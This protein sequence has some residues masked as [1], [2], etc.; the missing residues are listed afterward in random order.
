MAAAYNNIAGVYFQKQELDKVLEFALK[1]LDIRKRL[2]NKRNIAFNMIN[3]GSVFNSMGKT[4]SAISYI[5]QGIELAQEVGTLP[6][7]R[8]GYKTLSRIYESSNDFREANKY[9]KLFIEINDSI[10]R[11]KS[12]R[13][14][15][16]METKFETEKKTKENELLKKDIE[17]KKNF[18]LLLIVVILGLI[19]LSVN[20]FYFFKLKSKSLKQ[21]KKLLDQEKELHR[22]EKAEKESQKEHLESKIFAEKRINSLQK[23]KYETEIKFKNDQLA[24]SALCIVNKNEVLSQI[25]NKIK[26]ESKQA[27]PDKDIG[28]ELIRF[29]NNNIDFDQDWKK[30]KLEFEEIHPGFFGK[31]NEKHPGLSE[32]HIKLCAYLRIN[33]NTREISQLMNITTDSVKKNRQRLRKKLNIGTDTLLIDFMKSI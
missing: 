33:L 8:Y 30:F 32:N 12:A 16:E 3:I 24:N 22:L 19:V 29:I 14:I 15:A 25:K 13:A 21:N 5:N 1:S 7:I 6:Q 31:L 27:D 9:Q 2:K 23:E 20:L 11:E 4:D 28:N 26:S 10:F 17:I 18:Q